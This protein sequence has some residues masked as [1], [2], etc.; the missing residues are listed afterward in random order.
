MAALRIL[1]Q[2]ANLADQPA[3]SQSHQCAYKYNVSTI[4]WKTNIGEHISTD[5]A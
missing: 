4:V 3:A 2:H 5:R 1:D